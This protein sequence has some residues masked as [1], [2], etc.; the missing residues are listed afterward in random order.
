M[1][2]IDIPGMRLVEEFVKNLENGLGSTGASTTPYSGPLYNVIGSTDDPKHVPPGN[3]AWKQLLIDFG[4][5]IWP[6][7][8]CYVTNPT[9]SGNTHDQFNVGGHMTKDPNGSV[10]NS[11]CY[12]MPLCKYHNGQNRTSFSHSI[13]PILQ[14][15]G[16]MKAEMLATF[17][18]RLPSKD[19]Y[20]VLY[21]DDSGW[22]YKNL[23]EDQVADLKASVFDKF[24]GEPNVKF[25][26]LIKRVREHNQTIH[27]RIG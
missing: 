12:L 15:T 6:N 17:Q 26:V 22:S 25:H 21:Y 8:R 24:E 5:G 4:I 9:P 19:P 20:A 3:L 16:Y 23:S 10:L 11:T 14:L 27:Y 18:L 2:M 13:T 7:D 1:E